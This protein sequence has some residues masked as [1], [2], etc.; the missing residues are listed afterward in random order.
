V[1]KVRVLAAIMVLE[2]IAGG[3]RC[4]FDFNE[5]RAK[6]G[7]PVLGPIDPEKIEIHALPMARLARLLPEKLSDER[8]KWAFHM[9]VGYRIRAAM[10]TFGEE[11]LR[12]PSFADK[13]DR[14]EAYTRLAEEEEDLDRALEYI[15]AGRQA[16]EKMGHSHVPFDLQ[17]LQLRFAR[18]EPEHILRLIQHIDRQHGKEPNVAQTLTNTLIH[19]GMLNPDGT[20]AFAMRGSAEEEIPR[21]PAAEPSQLWT[22]D[23]ASPG[24]GGGKLWT[25]D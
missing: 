14:L 10:R 1:Y 20:P 22:P 19:F 2:D 17:E 13:P 25:P 7:L 5:L 24:S 3:L 12:R 6:L 15:E 11:L 16:M 4:N 9:A 23:S 18:R 8:L 21:E